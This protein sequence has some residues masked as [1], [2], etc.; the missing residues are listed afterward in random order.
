[1][2]QTRHV[3]GRVAPAHGESG[4]SLVEFLL[5]T[6]IL[7]VVA[8]AV[9]AMLSQT[10]RAASYQAEVQAVMDNARTAMDTVERTIRQAGNDPRQT[11]LVGLEIASAT[12]LRVRSDLTGSAAG[13][14]NPDKGDPDGDTGDAGEDVVILYNA[15]NRAV[16]LVPN[17]GSAQAIA[18]YISAFNMQYFDAAGAATGAGANVRKV[19][20]TL[21]DSTTLPDPQT[22][23]IFGMQQSSDIQIVNR[24]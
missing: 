7:L 15:T 16:E 5:S 12:Q 20:V 11:G 6:F 9:F 8:S 13:S 2:K 3:S 1:M 14:G 22:R 21:T 4:F 19:R 24:Q 17:G 10:Q 23:Q 18:N